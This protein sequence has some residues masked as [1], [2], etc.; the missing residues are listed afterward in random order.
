MG[1]GSVWFGLEE[2]GGLR[3]S[4]SE[5]VLVAEGAGMVWY[6]G[7]EGSSGGRCG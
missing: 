6:G 7:C 2:K 1:F 3:L 4:V 5:L